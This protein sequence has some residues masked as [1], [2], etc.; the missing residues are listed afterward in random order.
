MVDISFLLK[1]APEGIRLY[2]PFLGEVTLVDVPGKCIILKCKEKKYKFDPF[3]RIEGVFVNDDECEY[4][5]SIPNNGECMLYPHQNYREW[6]D[7]WGSAVFPQCVGCVIIYDNDIPYLV[8]VD[9]LY[10]TNP[11]VYGDTIRMEKFDFKGTRFATK[12]ETEKY[13][14]EL[15]KNGYEWDCVDGKVYRNPSKFVGKWLSFKNGEGGKE[16]VDVNGRKVVLDCPV[17]CNSYNGFSDELVVEDYK[18][19][20]FHL[21]ASLF[22]EWSFWDAK[23]GDI[24]CNDSLTFIFKSRRSVSEAYCIAILRNNE[25]GWQNSLSVN[26]VRLYSGNYFE[27]YKPA[28]KKEFDTLRDYLKWNNWVWDDESKS[29]FKLQNASSDGTFSVGDEVEYKGKKYR[30]EMVNDN[31]YIVKPLDLGQSEDACTT[32]PFSSFGDISRISRKTADDFKPFDRVYVSVRACDSDDETEYP[33]IFSHYSEKDG[34][35][36]TIDGRA[37]VRCRPYDDSE[38]DSED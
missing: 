37:W 20:V 2:S 13:F 35:Y 9:E 7:C 11:S 28:G 26:E 29:L 18:G 8:G 21:N 36:Y 33:N 34:F 19:R 14:F 5:M 23:C 1:N 30:F 4:V 22:T 38:N 32:I 24:L 6:N 3:G 12:D 25:S 16:R 27:D 15:G 17:M 31:G 10:T